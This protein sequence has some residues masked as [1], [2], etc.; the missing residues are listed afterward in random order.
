MSLWEDNDSICKNEKI[1]SMQIA[2]IRLFEQRQSVFDVDHPGTECGNHRKYYMQL[3][4][5]GYGDQTVGIFS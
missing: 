5:E 3:K 2:D 1:I 4:G